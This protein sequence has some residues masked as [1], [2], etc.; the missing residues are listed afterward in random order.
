MSN[1]T[2]KAIK[3]TFMELLD[4]HPLSR[5]TVKM[6]VEKCGINRNSFYYHYQDIPALIEEMIMEET[7]RIV[8]EYPSVDSVETA[9]KA[10]I[11]FASSYRRQLLHIYNSVN[12]DIFER[13]L[14]KVCDYVV[15]S[16]CG[17]VTGEKEEQ[18][19]REDLEVIMRFY[20]CECFGVV[21]EWLNGDMNGD[22]HSQIE[23]FCRLHQGIPEE[24]IARSHK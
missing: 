24:M 8:E 11:D 10:A 19:D 20:C 6:I 13:Y 23:R 12:R 18:L 4:E 22:V 3:E 7:N 15:K 5:I 9:L 14:W 16:Y 17:N 2:Q 1:L 21:I